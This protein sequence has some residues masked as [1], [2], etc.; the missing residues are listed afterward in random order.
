[1]IILNNTCYL[2]IKEASDIQYVNINNCS[3]LNGASNS[4]WLKNNDLEVKIC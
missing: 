1:M 3:F 2:V 4:K